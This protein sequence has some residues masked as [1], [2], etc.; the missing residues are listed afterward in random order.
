MRGAE[1]VM[2]S[3]L[4]SLARARRAAPGLPVPGAGSGSSSW[5]WVSHLLVPQ[6]LGLTCRSVT[7]WGLAVASGRSSVEAIGSGDSIQARPL[8]SPPPD[9]TC[10]RQCPSAA[11]DTRGFWA[12]G[13]DTS[14][15][16]RAWSWGLLFPTASHPAGH[17]V[18]GGGQSRTQ[19]AVFPSRGVKGSAAVYSNTEQEVVSEWDGLFPWQEAPFPRKCWVPASGEGAALLSSI[20]FPSCGSGCHKAKF[21]F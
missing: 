17:L 16:Q 13:K 21:Y 7:P 12:A 10:R 6:R 5:A 11:G 9:P 8:I 19:G 20:F 18:G 14:L 2:A 15:V 3:R 1:G 4:W